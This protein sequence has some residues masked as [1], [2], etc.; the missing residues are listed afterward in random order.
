MELEIRMQGIFGYGL[1]NENISNLRIV[2]GNRDPESA[3]CADL[4]VLLIFKSVVLS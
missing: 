4:G 2:P 1:Q 3:H